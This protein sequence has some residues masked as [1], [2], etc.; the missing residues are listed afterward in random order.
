MLYCILHNN[1]HTI[2]INREH[3][4]CS[5]VM[6]PTK[7]RNNNIIIIYL[8]CVSNAMGLTHSHSHWGSQTVSYLYI[9]IQSGIMFLL[10]PSPPPLLFIHLLGSPPPLRLIQIFSSLLLAHYLI[11]PSCS[12]FWLLLNTEYLDYSCCCVCMSSGSSESQ[13]LRFPALLVNEYSTLYK[14]A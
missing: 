6:K 8:C 2:N 5:S 10:I 7:C 4:R 3:S 14:F 13:I 9:R 11:V 12:D 1:A